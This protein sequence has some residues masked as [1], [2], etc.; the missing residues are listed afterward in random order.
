MTAIHMLIRKSPPP[1]WCMVRGSVVFRLL[2]IKIVLRFYWFLIPWKSQNSG[3]V[4]TYTMCLP[5]YFQCRW[6][7]G[8]PYSFLVPSCI[9]LWCSLQ[10]AS[11]TIILASLTNI[12]PQCLDQLGYGWSGFAFVPA[13][14]I[15][16]FWLLLLL[17]WLLQLRL[18]AC[19]C[20]YLVGGVLERLFHGAKCFIRSG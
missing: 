2:I 18:F 6:P 11:A 4:G 17:M 19:L 16:S 9:V 8:N 1:N 15:W 12:L 13:L 5:K 20:N 7:A 10:R 3:K 14:L